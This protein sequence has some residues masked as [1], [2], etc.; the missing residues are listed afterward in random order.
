MAEQS[1]ER[2][3]RLDARVADGIIQV[4]YVA[5]SPHVRDLSVS[6]LYLADTRT[7]QRGQPIELKLRLGGSDAIVVRGMVRRVDPGQGV[8]IE[9]IHVDAAD[10]RRI[11]EFIAKVSPDKISP[12]GDDIF[13]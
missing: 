1:R 11:K 2:D 3:R 8:A 10:R 4:E 6:G 12:A 7:L 9:F 5:P 13:S